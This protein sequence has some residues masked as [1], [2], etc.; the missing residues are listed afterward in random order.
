M[1][2]QIKNWNQAAQLQLSK[3]QSDISAQIEKEVQ[4]IE[5]NERAG[6]VGWSIIKTQAKH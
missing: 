3:G 5:K 4:S 6:T 1:S 2:Q